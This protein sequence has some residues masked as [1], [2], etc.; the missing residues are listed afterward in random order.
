[1]LD[2]KLSLQP[3]TEQKLKTILSSGIDN[4]RFAQ[5][6]I[7]YQIQELQRGILNLRIEL[8]EFEKKYQMSSE[9]F[10]EQFFRGILNDEADFMVWSGLVELMHRDQSQLQVLE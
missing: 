10:Y 5:S 8:D 3:D 4:E 9:L 1:M 2:I 7:N 6:V